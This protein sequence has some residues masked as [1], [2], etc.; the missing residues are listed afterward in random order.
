MITTMTGK[1]EQVH[2][3]S[4]KFSFLLL[5]FFSYFFSPYPYHHNDTISLY[6]AQC[7]L[8]RGHEKLWSAPMFIGENVY[9]KLYIYNLSHNFLCLLFT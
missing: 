9:N 4:K 8:V 6:V 2:D 7:T 5:L 1:K 3:D